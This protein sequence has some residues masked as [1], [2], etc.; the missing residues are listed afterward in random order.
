MSSRFETPILFIVFNRPDTT[1][2]VFEE[3]R[4]I[5]P[6]QLFVAADGPRENRPGEKEKCEEVRKFIMDNVDWDCEVKTLFREKN[7]GCG[8]AVSPAIT[9]YFQ[10]VEQ[11]I[12]L[13]DDCLPNPS[14]FSYCQELLDRYKDN[15]RVM[16]IAGA[17]FVPDF[18][19]GASYYFA[20]LMHCWGWAGWADR[21]QYY[22]FDLKSFT[23]EKIKYFSPDKNVQKYWLNILRRL[24][25]KEIDTWDYQWTFKI[26]E[27]NGLCVNPTKNLVSNI[28][29]GEDS[30]HTP[31]KNNPLANMPTFEIKRMIHPDKIELDSTAVNYIYQHHCGIELGSSQYNLLKKFYHYLI[32]TNGK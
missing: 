9:W 2:R 20:K 14:F 1:R 21:W 17:Q 19:N 6:K 23:E 10:N 16:H 28:G 13:E 18:E 24:K 3:I 27:M 26:V 30:T 25:R 7:L 31:D 29:F 32:N 5:K 8:K 11:G 4:R 15:K 22:D 12:V